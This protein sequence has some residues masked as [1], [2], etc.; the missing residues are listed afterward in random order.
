MLSAVLGA[1]N[2]QQLH[3]AAAG[4]VSTNEGCWNFLLFHSALP[5]ANSSP[6]G[7]ALG[8]WSKLVSD[9]F[10]DIAN[11]DA[12]LCQTSLKSFPVTSRKYS[13]LPSACQ[14]Y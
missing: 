4:N 7:H 10:S 14:R 12:H 2:E 9:L 11:V 3:F 8:T 6:S 13:E 5:C 1:L